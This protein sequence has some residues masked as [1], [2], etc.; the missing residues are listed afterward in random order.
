LLPKPSYFDTQGKPVTDPDAVV[1]NEKGRGEADAAGAYFSEQRIVKLCRA[2]Q[3]VGS[4][5]DITDHSVLL[6]GWTP[7]AVLP[8][9]VW[10]PP[11]LA[12]ALTQRRMAFIMPT[13]SCTMFAERV[14][15]AGSPECPGM[16]RSVR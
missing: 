2:G 13:Y 8:T 1:L 12:L 4:Q 14:G 15:A 9:P 6:V 7:A 10:R 11:A 3:V 16:G 5:C